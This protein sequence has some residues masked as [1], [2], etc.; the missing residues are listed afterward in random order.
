MLQLHRIEDGRSEYAEFLH[1]PKKKFTDFG[2]STFNKRC[3]V[4]CNDSALAYE[5]CIKLPLKCK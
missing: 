4:S 5:E 1:A 2:M 3:I